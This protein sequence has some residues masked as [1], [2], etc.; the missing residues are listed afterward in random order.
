[1]RHYRWRND[2]GTEI[3]L[4]DVPG[5]GGHEEGLGDLAAEEAKR[6]HLVL[7]VCDS[8]LTRAELKAIK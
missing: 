2:A 6:A 1:V 3:L 5:T 7:F 4:T 8:D